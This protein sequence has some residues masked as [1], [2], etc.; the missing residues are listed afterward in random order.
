MRCRARNDLRTF[1]ER[2]RPPNLD[3]TPAMYS[4]S[5][6]AARAGIGA[7][8][9]AC[10]ALTLMLPLLC[11]VLVLLAALLVEYLG[12][13]GWLRRRDSLAGQLVLIT[14]AAGGLGR[15]LALRFAQQGATLALW[16]VRRDALDEL[17]E[18]LLERGVA[19]GA[20]HPQCVD[21]A[22]AAAVAREA[23][24]QHVR[25]GPVR[26]L[27]NNA[28]IVY[29]QPLLGG[30]IDGGAAA[31]ASV[32]QLRRSLDV[33]VAAHFWTVRAFVPQMVDEGRGTVVT[34]GSI[35]SSLP[36]AGMAEYC[37]SKAAVSQLHAC[38]RWELRGARGIR[39]LLVRPY[40]IATPLFAGGAP[41]KV[42][43]LRALLPPLEAPYVAAR[44]VLAVQTRQHDRSN[45]NPKPKP[46]P[47]PNPNPNPKS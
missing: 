16:D 25:L 29:G 23:A 36:A 43:A 47:K 26:V 5:A 14:G 42:R 44:I 7:P 21:V 3:P 9:G 6:N 40:L 33:N 10:A 39:C 45:P 4:S 27:V 46:K 8:L 41:I 12:H 22:D 35:M 38:L 13:C 20:L 28:A 18:W 32:P 24:A 31:G 34:I 17:C 19:P 15:E 2:L 1:A 37:A 11:G 30:S